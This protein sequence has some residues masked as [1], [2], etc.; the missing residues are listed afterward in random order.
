MKVSDLNMR[1]API[2]KALNPEQKKEYEFKAAEDRERFRTELGLNTAQQRTECNTNDP[3][4]VSLQR[5]E[6]DNT[7]NLSIIGG[8]GEEYPYGGR[9]YDSDR[10]GFADGPYGKSVLSHILN[11]QSNAYHFKHTVP[12]MPW[13]NNDQTKKT[14]HCCVIP[15]VSELSTSEI[16]LPHWDKQECKLFVPETENEVSEKERYW[17][18]KKSLGDDPGDGGQF[19]FSLRRMKIFFVNFWFKDFQNKVE[20]RKQDTPDGEDVFKSQSDF[21]NFVKE[22]GLQLWG[23]GRT[24][25]HLCHVSLRT[26]SVLC[27]S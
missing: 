27:Q 18:C 9:C 4:I 8:L 5:L 12:M 1:L 20:R 17:S 24:L 26:L 11:V 13:D 7:A 21:Q 3:D 25:D 22:E 14:L 15:N 23:Q 19:R 6:S 10:N 2:W 16:P